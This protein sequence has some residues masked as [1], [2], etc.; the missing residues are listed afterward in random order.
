[1]PYSHMNREAELPPKIMPDG[2]NDNSG[3]PAGY[4][5]QQQRCYGFRIGPHQLLVSQGSY[6]ELLTHYQPAPLP[7]APPHF[8]GLANVRGNLVPVYQLEPLLNLQAESKPYALV[9]GKL[10]A[11]P[12]ALAI[13]HK[14]VQLDLASLTTVDMPEA[15]PDFLHRFIS[16]NH[17]KGT[18]PWSTIDHEKLF[19]HLAN[20]H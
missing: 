15:L 19:Q 7:N 6:C 11:T 10:S 18:D 16:E 9:I 5:W 3:P 2:I 4:R 12:A 1:M 14:P 8:L 20:E 13:K 17:A